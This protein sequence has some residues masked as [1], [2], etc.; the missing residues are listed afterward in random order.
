MPLKELKAG[1]A[2]VVPDGTLSFSTNVVR[3]IP[4]GPAFGLFVDV[5]LVTATPDGVRLFV[6]PEPAKVNVPLIVGEMVAAAVGHKVL[7]AP[8]V[9]P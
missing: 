4:A 6:I 9:A 1:D 7:V 8:T 5:K 2:K 3:P